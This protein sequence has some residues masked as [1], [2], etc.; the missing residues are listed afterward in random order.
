MDDGDKNTWGDPEVSPVEPLSTSAY[1]RGRQ[2]FIVAF[3]V[4]L[5]VIISGLEG[6]RVQ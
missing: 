5:L 2:L 3:S 1:P 4:S 6:M